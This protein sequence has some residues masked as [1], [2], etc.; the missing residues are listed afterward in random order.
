MKTQLSI[1]FLILA[2]V[3]ACAHATA[4]TRKPVKTTHL[5]NKAAAGQ[6]TQDTDAPKHPLSEEQKRAIRSIL[7]KAKLEGVPLALMGAQ[8]AKEFDENILSET[9][10]A[11][12]D[13]KATRKLLDGLAGV[14]ELRLQT[15]RDV[16]ALLTPEQKQ[17]LRAEMSKPGTPTALL[18]V[19]ARVFKLPEE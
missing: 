17:L 9:P 1:L 10:S 16:V 6:K 18:E 2:C 15:I 8:G 13:Q 3:V 7:T 19:L 5:Q 12:S 4:Q 11:E 14:A